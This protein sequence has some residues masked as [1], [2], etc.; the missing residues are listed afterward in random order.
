MIADAQGELD[1]ASKSLDAVFLSNEASMDAQLVALAIQ[2]AGARIAL[3]VLQVAKM[4]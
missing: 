4:S 2:E 3:T 1:R